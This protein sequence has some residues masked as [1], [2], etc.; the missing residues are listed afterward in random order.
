MT[1]TEQLT[2]RVRINA[3]FTP[4]A[5]IDSADLFAGRKRQVDRVMGVVFQRGQHAIIF[6]ERGVGKTSLS[7]IIFDLLVLLGK[8]DYQTA[9]YTAGADSD[10]A[11]MWR[12]IFKRLT[13]VRDAEISLQDLLPEN[14]TPE[15]IK[16]ALQQMD[17][18]SIIIV[19]EFDRVSDDQ[20]DVLLADT[21]KTLSDNSV[22]TTL[23]LVG[24][25]DSV[26][27]LI[28]EH[29]SIERALVQI[30][31]P[32][33]SKA[34]L[35]E[36]IDKGL[37]HAGMSIEGSAKNRI[38]E[39][40]QGLPHFTHLLTRFAALTA[41]EDSRTNIT[42]SDLSVAIRESVMG[43]NQSVVGAYHKATQSPRENL[44]KEVLLSAAL[45]EKDELGFFFAGDLRGPMSVVTGKDYDIPAYSRHL[46]DFCEESRGKILQR[47]GERKRF[48]FRF[49]NPLMEPFVVLKGVADGLISESQIEGFAK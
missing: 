21:I 40:S 22:N 30:Q 43:Y 6:G 32:R 44:Y 19:D 10:F 41:A 26:D 3:S 45:A 2:L 29:Q 18:P 47:Q 36:A 4:S 27:Q 23:I 16:E 33:M 28:S 37:R 8:S 9:R 7:N 46:Y 11:S 31:M 24:V 17:T 48:R 35:I 34:E 12:S 20:T 38:A 13:V 1:D 39:L 25:A 42:Q 14:P 49:T 5:P 15:D